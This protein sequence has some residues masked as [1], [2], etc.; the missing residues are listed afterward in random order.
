MSSNCFVV[1]WGFNVDFNNVLV[2]S[3]VSIILSQGLAGAYRHFK[4]VLS[5]HILL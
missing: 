1:V 3:R 2:I 4:P 5:V